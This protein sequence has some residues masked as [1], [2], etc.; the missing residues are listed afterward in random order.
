M[1]HEKWVR[2]LKTV[3]LLFFLCAQF[4][5]FH[6]FLLKFSFNADDPLSEAVGGGMLYGKYL[7]LDKV[8]DAQRLLSAEDNHLVHD[9]HLFIVTHQGIER[10]F[11]F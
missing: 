11:R 1:P 6:V 4:L 10:F 2:Y 3:F 7:Q 9:E 8:L 5:A